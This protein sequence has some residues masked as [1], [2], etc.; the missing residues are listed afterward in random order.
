MGH[1]GAVVIFMED[2]YAEDIIGNNDGFDYFQSFEEDE[3]N[4]N[5]LTFFAFCDNIST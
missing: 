1:C 2:E 3:N 4:K 5:C